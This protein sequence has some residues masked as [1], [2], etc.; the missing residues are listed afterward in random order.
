M[1]N[2]R[3][4]GLRLPRDQDEYVRDLARRQDVEVSRIIRRMITYCRINMPENWLPPV[5]DE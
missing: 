2:S 4:A 1:V 3:Q 5:Q